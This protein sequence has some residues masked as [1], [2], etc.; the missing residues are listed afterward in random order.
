MHSFENFVFFSTFNRWVDINFIALDPD[1]VSSNF[2]QV[3]HHDF[4][5]F[6]LDIGLSPLT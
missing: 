2:I 4:E 5:D 6:M 1:P 3:C